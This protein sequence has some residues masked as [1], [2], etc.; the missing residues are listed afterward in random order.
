MSPYIL[1]NTPHNRSIFVV[2]LFFTLESFFHFKLYVSFFPPTILTIYVEIGFRHNFLSPAAA[3]SPFCLKAAAS[4]SPDL[5]CRSFLVVLQI[6]SSLFR[7][8]L[9]QAIS[10]GSGALQRCSRQSARSPF[11]CESRRCLLLLLFVPVCTR[12]ILSR[13]RVRS[14]VSDPVDS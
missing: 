13:P 1:H 3:S 4:F 11:R 2:F 8:A 14:L 12:V 7:G 5:H 10:S 6:S 9:I